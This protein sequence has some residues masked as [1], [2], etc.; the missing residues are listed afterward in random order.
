MEKDIKNVIRSAA[1]GFGAFLCASLLLIPICALILSFLK[2]PAPFSNPVAT[3]VLYLSALIGGG[4]AQKLS[5]SI[6]CPIIPGGAALLLSLL[7]ALIF[8]AGE[9]S[10][11]IA[12]FAYVAIPSAF[13]IGGIIM[14]L[15]SSKRP[16]RRKRRQ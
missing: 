7:G 13:F 6:L 4:V 2:D 10:P 11:L 15:S 5:D 8:K 16:R 1:F 14:G 12:I 3:V 9:L